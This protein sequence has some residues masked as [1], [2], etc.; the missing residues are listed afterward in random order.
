MTS[1]I[2]SMV[3]SYNRPMQCDLLLKTF[4]KHC[5]D[6]DSIDKYVIYKASDQRFSD[7]YLSCIEEES[8]EINFIKEKD[9]YDDTYE[10]FRNEYEYV[11]FMTD[12]TI[13]FHPFS[14][15]GITKLMD[16]NSNILNFSLRLGYNTKYCYSLN[17]D[18][19]LPTD[20]KK[21][22][23]NKT[24]FLLWDWTK[25]KFDWGYPLEVSSS[26]LRSGNLRNF[27]QLTRYNNPNVMEW[28]LDSFKKLVY[29]KNLSASFSTSV[30]FS[31]PMNKV[32]SGNQNRSA[33]N[34]NYTV[35]NLLKLYQQGL[36]IDESVFGSDFLPNSAHQE[37]S[38]TFY[39]KGERHE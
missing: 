23:R 19:G 6:W 28:L 25:A 21:I 17:A 31:S 3:F 8:G 11:L 15:E 24:E 39:G 26:V 7:A 34:P 20:M 30:A 33:I 27:S 32:S 4:W 2:C 38:F 14:V 22:E 29:S 9:F 10:I 16:S 1:N 12:D 18:Q 37:I 36:R 5:L 13:F 35:E